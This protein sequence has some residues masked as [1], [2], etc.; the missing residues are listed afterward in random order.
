[1]INIFITYR[2]NLACPYCFARELIDEYPQDMDEARFDTLLS[3]MSQAKLPA[4]AFIG[5]EPTLHP[6]LADMIERTALAGIT[7]VLF[8][9][10]L[11]RLGLADRL[12]PLVSNFVVNYNDPS[13][14]TPAQ[15]ATLRATLSQLRD[16]GAR[17]TF[18]KNFSRECCEFEYLLA[19]CEE[20]GVTSVRYDISRPSASAANDHFTNADMAG[21]I[22]HI[23]RFVKGCEERDIRTGLDCSVRLCDLRV[24][25]RSYLERVSMKFTGVCHPSIDVHPDL[26]ASYCL[27]MRDI[28]VPDVTAF[29]GRDALMWHFAE[30]VR[31]VR[32]ANVSVECFDCRDFMRRCQ[33]GCMA[34][35]RPHH[36]YPDGPACAVNVPEVE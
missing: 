17:I 18:S 19:G 31:P 33:G 12:A 20:Y 26:S 21:M 15:R 8:T 22:S 13:L 25:D 1:M 5:G 32:Q 35:N 11:F 10:G 2:C 30:L 16:L 29:P 34:L 27:P 24:E 23:V 28:R 36:I 3:W 4:A 6:G 14:Y 9:N 7:P